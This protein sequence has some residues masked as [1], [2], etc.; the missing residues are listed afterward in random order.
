MPPER[1]DQAILEEYGPT[2]RPL[3]EAC[4]TLFRE[5]RRS[6][7]A[8]AFNAAAM[9]CRAAAEAATWHYLNL[10]WTGSGYA[11]RGIPRREDTLEVA[12]ST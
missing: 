9:T 10:S 3:P 8:G 1:L 7:D 12:R 6:H 2:H 5:A 11:A 4:L